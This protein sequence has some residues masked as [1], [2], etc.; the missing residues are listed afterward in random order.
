MIYFN[1]EKQFI[2]VLNNPIYLENKFLI[3]ISDCT[4]VMLVST[5]WV[6]KIGN[7]ITIIIL[8]LILMTTNQTQTILI[9]IK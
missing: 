8:V 6:L 1:V 9:S 3:F 7:I 4:K 5:R 2:K